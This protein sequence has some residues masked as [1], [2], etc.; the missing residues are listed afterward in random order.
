MPQPTVA[1]DIAGITSPRIHR[2]YAYWQH[3]CERRDGTPPK[4][5]DIAPD[6]IRGVLPN[7]MIV[8]VE[9][10]PLRFR[11][12]L[13]GT[14]VVEYNGLE[15]TGRYLG[16]IGWPEEQDLIDSYAAVVEGRRPVFGAFAWELTTGRM[17]RCEFARLPLSEDGE[18]VSQILAM[19]D[20]DFPQPDALPSG[21]QTTR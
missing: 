17:G 21:G 11:Y 12:R 20:Y 4:R 8:D 15:F 2:L 18:L 16:E 10:D 14:R 6:Q 1:L 19:E 5:G 13:V 9:R 3:Q 7:I